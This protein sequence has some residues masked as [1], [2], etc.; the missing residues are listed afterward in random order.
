MR[1]ALRICL[2]LS[3]WLGAGPLVSGQPKYGVTVRTVNRGALAKAKTYE[4]T[5]SQPSPDSK[6]DA[7]IVAAVDRELAARG[8][9]KLAS[10]R[11][12]V[13]VTYRSLSRTDVTA[14]K[15]RKDSA[16]REFAVGTLVVDLTDS[17]SRQL[18]FGVRMDTPIE[19][20]PA[21]IETTINGAVKAMFEKYPPPPKK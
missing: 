15:D 2:A 7:L 18:L 6:V 10:G 8:L 3:L 20:D 14:T 5:E 17:T 13:E 11:P 16:F 9:A 21:T 12:D 1:L 19:W 4:W